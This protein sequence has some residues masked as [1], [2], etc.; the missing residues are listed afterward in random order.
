MH[1]KVYV[2]LILPVGVFNSK[3]RLACILLI[4]IGAL[5]FSSPAVAGLFGKNQTSSSSSGNA[6]SPV[7][8]IPI[9]DEAFKI[10]ERRKMEA[11]KLVS[12]GLEIMRE[13]EKK[14]NETLI[15]KGRIKKEIGEKQLQV[16][17]EQT[18]QKKKEDKNYDW[19]Q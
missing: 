18:E 6:Q 4:V 7:D 1:L 12:E 8:E 13:G 15:T 9:R 16:L 10:M 14:K 17:K 3:M 19:Q 5:I 2:N 11:H